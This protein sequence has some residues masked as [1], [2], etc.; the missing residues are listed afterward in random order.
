MENKSQIKKL[1]VIDWVIVGV[2]V[3]IVTLVVGIG[4]LIVAIFGINTKD[5]TRWENNFAKNQSESVI[6]TRVHWSSGQIYY[7]VNQ[8]SGTV[9]TRYSIYYRKN[10]GSYILEFANG[11]CNENE[12]YYG[13][14]FMHWTS[15]I[16]KYAYK[17]TKD[18][19]KN[20]KSR[21]DILL[22]LPK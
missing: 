1:N 22:F 14:Y 19:N 9:K 20:V 7:G 11:Y 12:A 6:E 3:G 5:S 8:L 4:S 18:T 10:S 21:M 17:L 2:I 16:D 13:D 15:G